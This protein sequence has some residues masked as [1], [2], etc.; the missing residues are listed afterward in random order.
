[1]L[2]GVFYIHQEDGVLLHGIGGIAVRGWAI[3]EQTIRKMNHFIIGIFDVSRAEQW[4]GHLTTA[5]IRTAFGMETS[6]KK[7]LS[8]RCLHWLGN[9]TRMADDWISKKNFCLDGY[10]RLNLHTEPNSDRET[11]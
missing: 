1:L 9:T 10:H 2:W 4:I 8:V 5:Q 6:L 11:R 7:L 3:K